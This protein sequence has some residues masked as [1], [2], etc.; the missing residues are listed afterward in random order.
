MSSRLRSA[1]DTVS[2]LVPR[3]RVE[4][5]DANSVPASP[6]ES[7]LGAVVWSAK[8]VPGPEVVARRPACAAASTVASRSAYR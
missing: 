1:P 4:S 5:R 6:S 8:V 2:K 7:A 3:R